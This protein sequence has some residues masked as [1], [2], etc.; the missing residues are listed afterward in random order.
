MEASCS[1]PV[2]FH[3]AVEYQV[4][5]VGIREGRPG[6]EKMNG[7][8]EALLKQFEREIGT[9]ALNRRRISWGR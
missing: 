4:A 5:P 6:R 8:A 9:E 1:S 3:H 7:V 2:G